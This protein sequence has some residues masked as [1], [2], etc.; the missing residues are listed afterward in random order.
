MRGVFRRRL[1]LGGAAL[2]LAPW[3]KAAFGSF[4]LKG[5]ATSPSPFVAASSNGR[6]F[7]KNGSPWLMLAD[8]A[9]AL[10]NIYGSDVT[11]YLSARANQGFTAIQFDLVATSYVGATYPY[12]AASTN[13]AVYA[14]TNR[15]AITSGYALNSAYWTLMDSYVSAING[16][17]MTAILNPYEGNV[18]A[19]DLV[20]AGNAAC[21]SYGQFLGNRFKNA[22]V[23]WH[24]GNDLQVT[25]SAIFHSFEKLAR[26]I[27]AADSN[28]LMT[29]ELFDT[30]RG[31]AG[32][33]TSFDNEGGYGSFGSVF[34]TKGI[35]GSYTYG[36]TYGYTGIAYNGSG[37]SIRGAAGTNLA[38]PC[39]VILLEAN[40]LGENLL[41]DG[42]SA[43]TYRKQSWWLILAGGLGGYIFGTAWTWKFPLR[44]QSHM[45]DGVA[46][47]Q[48]WLAFLKSI[49]WWTLQPDF[50]RALAVTGSTGWNTASLVGTG[51]A[52]SW[53]S[54]ICQAADSLTGGA[55][56]SV[57]YFSQGSVQSL[58]VRM[59]QFA[60]PVTAK[61]VDPTSG[62]SSTISGSPFT[63]SGTCRF[64]PSGNNSAGDPDWALLLTA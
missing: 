5:G 29:V 43:I 18:A 34:G 20:N 61:W 38:S 27:L 41:G 60:R 33:S 4:A 8:S 37:T 2:A 36:P 6:Y 63:N 62:S 55:H 10:V 40:Y 31:G 56:L 30:P 26:G 28:H 47:V 50:G 17:G 16:L 23:I 64:S 19:T 35:N 59:N 14:F 57:A 32:F 52:Y 13:G 39:P 11:N 51:W 12:G 44:W 3:A 15:G 21:S 58:T 7:V 42:S 22:D 48:T 1:L 49:N 24:L 46:D 9:Q 54:Y 53:D 45:T 25:N